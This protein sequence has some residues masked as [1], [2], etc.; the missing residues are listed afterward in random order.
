MISRVAFRIGVGPQL[1]HSDRRSPG[2]SV[3]E[4]AFLALAVVAALLSS[5]TTATSAQE[6]SQLVPH[7]VKL[8]SVEYK[9]KRAVKLSEDG[10][11]PNAQAYAV[12]KGSAFHNGTIELEVAGLP[13]AGAA[14][15][16][17][18]SSASAFAFRASDTSTSIFGRP[19]DAPTIR[20]VEIIRC[21]TANTPISISRYCASKRPRS[22]RVMWIS[23]RATGPASVLRSREPKRGCTCTARRN[24]A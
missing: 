19:T 7:R 2:E 9:G 22:M 13:A 24:R 11:V 16:L 20:C 6:P 3:M 5:G 15:A 18:A 8:E 4:S 12:V 23:S 14:K 1:G 10:T 17:A 21:S